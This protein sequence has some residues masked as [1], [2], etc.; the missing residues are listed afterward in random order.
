MSEDKVVLQLPVLTITNNFEYNDS[1]EPKIKL[2]N[3]TLIIR[4]MWH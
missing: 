4:M 1:T 2:K 3:G